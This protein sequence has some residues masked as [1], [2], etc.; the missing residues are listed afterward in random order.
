MAITF[1]AEKIGFPNI[2]K[3]DTKNWIK[4]V[5]ENYGKK[6]GDVNYLF[7]DDE[8]IR[9]INKYYLSHDFYTDI[10]TFDY[11]EKNQILGDIVISLETV[12]SNSEKYDTTF[13]EE[14]NRVIIHGI[15]HLC[16]INDKSETEA[17]A[18]RKAENAALVLLAKPK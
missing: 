12:R 9:E 11:S 5:A 3:R 2:R 6:I 18:M 13:E 10:I 17:K 8:K 16:G 14:L 1:Q 4:Q 15:L 7:C